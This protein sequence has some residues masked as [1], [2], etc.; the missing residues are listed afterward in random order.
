MIDDPYRELAI[1]QETDAL[2]DREERRRAHLFPPEHTD[3]D[4][5]PE[6]GD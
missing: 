2:L 1:E 5:P 3:A 6:D 4:V